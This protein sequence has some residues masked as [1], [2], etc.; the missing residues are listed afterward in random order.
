MLKKIIISLLALSMLFS[1]TACDAPD[2]TT[3][4]TTTTTTPKPTIYDN[5]DFDTTAHTLE[6]YEDILA[7][8]EKPS[9]FIHYE[10]LASLGEF[11]CFDTGYVTPHKEFD[12]YIYELDYNGI[13]LSLNIFAHDDPHDEGWY[14]RELNAENLNTDLRTHIYTEESDYT[15]L[16]KT[17]YFADPMIRFEYKRSTG[18]L[19]CI[20]MLYETDGQYIFILLLTDFTQ[21]NPNNPDHIINRLL[22][23]N[24]AI[25][26]KDELLQAIYGT[27][28]QSPTE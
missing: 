22:N 6:E 5:E 25:Q 18:M 11:K 23:K 27:P 19:N 26:A 13:G 24:T 9:G 1:S 10:Q 17:Y 7:Q 3:Q 8:L 21:F 16:S 15:S 12:M 28:E 14:P 20:T 4:T 2:S